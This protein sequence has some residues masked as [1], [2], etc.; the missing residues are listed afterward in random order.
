M[1]GNGRPR[2]SI[3]AFRQA[4]LL[5]KNEIFVFVEGY[6]DRFSYDQIV[7]PVCSKHNL[8]YE[9]VTSEEI[10]GAG[11]KSTLITLFQLLKQSNFL[12]RMSNAKRFA[13]IFYFDKDIDDI[14]RKTL[15]SGHVV[16]TDTYELENLCY[17][18]GDLCKAIA[19]AVSLDLQSVRQRIPDQVIWRRNAAAGWREWVELCVFSK[20][21]GI[22]CDGGYGSKTSPIHKGAYGKLRKGELRKRMTKC[23]EQLK[24]KKPEFE[25]EFAQTRALVE[26]LYYRGMHDTVF[27]GKWYAHFVAF[28]A[29]KAAGNRRIEANY[30]EE[31]VLRALLNSINFQSDTFARLRL[32][33]ESLIT[34]LTS[35]AT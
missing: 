24:M 29:K 27:K 33:L 7:A 11:G 22:V 17:I 23:R 25:G 4:M 1:A 9:I 34:V 16:Y 8:N 2:H 28:D 15:S 3:E 10:E 20:T 31:K 14:E 18:E 12:L 13:A 19:A 30:V 6:T 26:D 35:H 21:H 32:P 5:S